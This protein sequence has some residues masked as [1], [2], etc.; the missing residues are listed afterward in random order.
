MPSQVIMTGLFGIMLTVFGLLLLFK[1]SIASDS[2]DDR[3][4]RLLVW[5]LGRRNAIVF[6]RYLFGPLLVLAGLRTL[7]ST[8]GW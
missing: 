6:L 2:V 5:V 7:A 3:R 1:E 8:W 4:N